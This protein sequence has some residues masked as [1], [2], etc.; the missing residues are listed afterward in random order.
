MP[1]RKHFH[2]TLQGG[3]FGREID[4]LVWRSRRVILFTLSLNNLALLV[5]P[6]LAIIEARRLCL[7]P[8]VV[9]LAPAVIGGLWFQDVSI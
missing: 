5:G 9:I 8:A 4:S 3:P 7:V 2:R 1:F 6:D